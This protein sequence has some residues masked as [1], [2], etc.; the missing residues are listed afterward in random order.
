M[1]N[2]TI[3][4]LRLAHRKQLEVLSLLDGEPNEIIR[5]SLI[6][7]YSELSAHVLDLTGMAEDEMLTQ[8]YRKKEVVCS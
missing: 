6:T 5:L 1:T 2:E 4:Q 8:L 3:T 7:I